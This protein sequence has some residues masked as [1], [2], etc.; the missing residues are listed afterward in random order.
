M[1]KEFHIR[2]DYRRLTQWKDTDTV[3]PHNYRQFYEFKTAY[4]V[5]AFTVC[6]TLKLLFNTVGSNLK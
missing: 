5:F 4:F 2:V 1:S 3:L 6:L